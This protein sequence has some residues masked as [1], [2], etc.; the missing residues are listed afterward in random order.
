MQVRDDRTS[1]SNTAKKGI[2]RTR[3]NTVCPGC[4]HPSPTS[5]STLVRLAAITYRMSHTPSLLPFYC[6]ELRDYCE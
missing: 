4:P 6:K 2:N 3:Q 5:T 1:V